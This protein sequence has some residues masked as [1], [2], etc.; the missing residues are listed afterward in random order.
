MVETPSLAGAACGSR[1]T[2]FLQRATLFSSFR[3]VPTTY[4]SMSNRD[5]SEKG[6]TRSATTS[7]FHQFWHTETLQ[8]CIADIIRSTSTH[9]L[10]RSASISS[11]CRLCLWSNTRRTVRLPLRRVPKCSSLFSYCRLFISEK[12]FFVLPSS[13]RPRQTLECYKNHQRRIETPRCRGPSASE[14]SSSPRKARKSGEKF[15]YRTRKLG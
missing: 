8:G 15:S 12:L 7:I 10:R 13:C 11:R 9:I 4:S 14:S 2:S 5:I 1:C 6:P 3:T